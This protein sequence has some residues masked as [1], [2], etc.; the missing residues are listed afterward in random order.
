MDGRV[1]VIAGYTL[2]ACLC[3]AGCLDPG[4][5]AGS[6]GDVYTDAREAD[7]SPEASTD[8]AVNSDTD[9]DL[10]V[11][12]EAP[13]VATNCTAT[14]EDTMI[15]S[16]GETYR[17]VRYWSDWGNP[18]CPTWWTSSTSPGVEFPTA[19]AVAADLGCDATCVYIAVVAASLLNCDGNKTGYDFYESKPCA[20]GVYATSDGVFED[21]CDWPAYACNCD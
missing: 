19:E 16:C 10:E 8:T 5:N 12:A 7:H 15:L 4:L 3:L 20:K 6:I 17:T 1:G 18:A 9:A 13:V 21:L 14:F 2:T 11:A